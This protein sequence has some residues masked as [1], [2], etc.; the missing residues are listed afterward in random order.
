MAGGID[1]FRWHH[2]S[3]T[4]PKFG[5]I[6][7][8]AGVRLGDVLAIWAFLL[9]SAS[10]NEPRGTIGQVDAEA[11]EFLLGI[12]EGAVLR[13]LDAM[14]ERGL[15]LAGGVVAA[16]EK[17]QPKRERDDDKS[18]DRVRA[19]RER[20]RQEHP[21]NAEKRQETPRE[22]ESREESIEEATASSRRQP[23]AGNVPDCPYQ[24]IVD[25]YM[26]KLPELPGVRVMDE[27]RK[28]C[29]K[30]FWAWVF[31]SKRSDGQ[32]RAPDRRPGPDVDRP[33]LRPSP[34]E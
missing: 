8:K 11:L 33:V 20:Q 24:S 1:W 16:W 23:K 3:V 17:R 14:T 13:I 7:K 10:S 29:I 27:K 15:L 5:L 22:E 34:C 12:E 28:R 31:T 6:A 9:E 18:T 19:F 32:V 25:L 2:G 26:E 21:C 4:D 30:A